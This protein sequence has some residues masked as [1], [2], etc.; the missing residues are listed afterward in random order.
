LDR[1]PV[2]SFSGGGPHALAL[3]ARHPDR[4]TAL[5]VMVGAAPL[6]E[7]RG[8]LLGVNRAGFR[9][10]PTGLRALY[11]Y[12]EQIGELLDLGLDL[13]SWRGRRAASSASPR[14]AVGCSP[15]RWL[16]DH[17]GRLK[18]LTLLEREDI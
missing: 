10:R 15:S 5:G 11:G 6:P 14:K 3:A 13:A 16:C 9:G 8:A 17:T 7:E 12:L 18:L 4:V 2:I 1:V